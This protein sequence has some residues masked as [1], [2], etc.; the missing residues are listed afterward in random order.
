MT[1]VFWLNF[2]KKMRALSDHLIKSLKFS[3]KPIEAIDYLWKCLELSDTLGV[4]GFSFVKLGE[5]DDYGDITLCKR[6]RV[7]SI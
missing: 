4:N 3:E 7:G 6:N 1:S 2:G 5:D